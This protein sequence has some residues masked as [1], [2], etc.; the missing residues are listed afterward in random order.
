MQLSMICLRV[1]LRN[2]MSYDVILHRNSKTVRKSHK[3]KDFY[4]IVSNLSRLNY[5]NFTH[6]TN[7][8][9]KA[10]YLSTKIKYLFRETNLI[11]KL[12]KNKRL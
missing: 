3:M 6:Y 7:Y 11:D 5:E 12:K 8:F 1:M 10:L 2:M 9:S 4:C